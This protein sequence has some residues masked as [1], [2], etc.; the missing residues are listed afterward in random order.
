MPSFDRPQHPKPRELSFTDSKYA[1][2]TCAQAVVPGTIMYDYTT[3]TNAYT[4]T[5]AGAYVA[6]GIGTINVAA[7]GV[8]T[9]IG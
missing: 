5:G 6:V 9:S 1:Y 2:I 3:S 8:I 4:T 7:G